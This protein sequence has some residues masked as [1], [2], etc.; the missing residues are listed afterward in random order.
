MFLATSFRAGWNRAETDFPNYYTAAVLVRK[1]QPLHRYYDWTWFQ[2][3]INYTGIDK[4]LGSYIPQTPLTMLPMVPLAGFTP[5]TAKRIWLIFNLLFL[6]GAIAL[7]ARIT[8]FSMSELT[9]LAF[10]GYGTLH[11]NFLLGQYY[12]FLLFLLVL[13]FYLLSRNNRYGGGFVFGTACALKIYGG[14]LLLYF[15]A[16]RDRRAF[17]G[18]ISGV[19]FLGLAAIAIFGWSEVVYFTRHVLPRALQGETIDPYNPGNGTISTLL[20]R[21][22]L[23]EAELNP[24]PFFPTPGLF[25][26]FQSLLTLS[27]LI[28]PL[29]GIRGSNTPKRDFAWFFLAMMLASPN[30]ASYT[31]ILLLLPVVLLLEDSKTVERV[32]LIGCYILLAIPLRPAV[33]FLFPKVWLLTLLFV[34]TSRPYLSRIKPKVTAVTAL[35]ITLASLASARLRFDKYLQ[36]PPHRW[37]HVALQRRPIFASHPAVLRFGIVYQSIENLQYALGWLHNGKNE[38]FYFNGEVFQP[39]ALSDHGPIEFELVAE[40]TSRMMLFDPLTKKLSPAAGP[41]PLDPTSSITSPNGKCVAFTRDIGGATQ[42]FVKPV[43][44]GKPVPLTGG[45]CNTGSP[46]WELDSEGLIFASDCGRGIGL[47]TLYRAR[48]GCKCGRN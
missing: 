28:F 29:L 37:Q 44:G 13:A 10:A 7:L 22:F 40:G 1:G 38:T 43:A 5:Q 36:E 2:R 20:R 19:S 21:A 32:I 24:H 31:F 34:I 45:Y 18:F 17:I 27:L 4:Q 42:V 46:A 16:K 39:V 26:F 9:L 11:R 47:S 8:R 14:P 48:I 6:G 41:P 12:V 35:L 3:Q 30:T 15:G 33:S 25:F 23:G